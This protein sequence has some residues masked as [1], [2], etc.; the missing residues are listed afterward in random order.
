MA[1]YKLDDETLRKDPHDVFDLIEKIGEGSY[2]SV[3]SARDRLKDRLVAIKQ[4]KLSNEL[5]EVVKEISIMQQ[6]DNS[7]I[8]RYYGSYFK[9][10]YLWIVMEFC[11]GG[12]VADIIRLR[13]RPMNE[14][15]IACILRPTL[16]AMK[17]LHSN[18][19]IHRDI[20]A[21]NIL[22]SEKG[23]AKL[24]DFG[25]AGQL[26]DN[27]VKRN[28]LVG[29]PYWMAPEVIQEIGYDTSADIWSLGITII[30]MAEGK[31]P[32]GDIHP[33]R[34][35][36]MI[37]TKPP[38]T[39]TDN[40]AWSPELHD[41]I[42]HCLVKLADARA[43][44]AELLD[45]AF[46]SKVRP[47]REVLLPI[48]QEAA[49]ALTRLNTE[50]ESSAQEEDGGD[51]GTIVTHDDGTGTIVT[52]SAS[53]EPADDGNDNNEEEMGT[54]VKNEDAGTVQAGDKTASSDYKPAFLAHFD[55]GGD[56]EKPDKPAVERAP[57][58]PTVLNLE[59]LRRRLKALQPEMDREIAQLKALYQEKRKP[60]L[61]AIAAKKAEITTN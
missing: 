27:M 5:Q 12:S 36:F 29:T 52:N 41:V 8:V 31:P 48:V 43:T 21:G 2:G 9:K 33:M 35:I 53:S 30:E 18:R 25:V 17:Y 22:L 60:I 23:E 51:V 55:N 39:L 56:K 14:E 15:Q 37:P 7:S 47:A 44:A 57:S 4:V 10:G 16:E 28:T 50:Q 11:S 38:P 6:C 42:A 59:D 13:R 46:V 20:K 24:A 1:D 58:A 40:A 49:A 26:S 34:A 32:Y 19:K 61:E 54:W 45:H 3:H